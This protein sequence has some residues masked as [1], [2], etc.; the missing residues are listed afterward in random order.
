M[1]LPPGGVGEGSSAAPP[2]EG[3]GKGNGVASFASGATVAREVSSGV[4]ASS[5]GAKR[6]ELPPPPPPPLLPPLLLPH[7]A[8]APVASASPRHW[9][10]ARRGRAAS[11]G[12]RLA[13][14][15]W[16]RR[17]GQYA[18]C[19]LRCLRSHASARATKAVGGH[20]AQST[21]C[22]HRRLLPGRSWCLGGIGLARPHPLRARRPRASSY[23]REETPG[24]V[25]RWQL[26]CV[27]SVL[28]WP[29]RDGA[30]ALNSAEA[31]VRTLQLG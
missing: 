22:G 20:A 14:V 17:T 19:L 2:W 31:A 1:L 16:Q 28:A 8:A 13:G 10:L 30:W 5:M 24:R 12:G 23:A 11:S 4:G 9:V 21:C 3:A 25:H 18:A 26:A 29:A 7:F 27:G 15:Q 6:Q